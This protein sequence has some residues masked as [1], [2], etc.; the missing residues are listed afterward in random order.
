M[1]R[2]GWRELRVGETLGPV[3]MPAVIPSLALGAFWMR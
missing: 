1:S 3:V 2:K